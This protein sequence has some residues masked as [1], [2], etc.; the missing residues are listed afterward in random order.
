MFLNDGRVVIS[1]FII[2]FRFLSVVLVIVFLYG[3]FIF[4]SWQFISDMLFLVSA[5]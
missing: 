4:K 1:L 2:L 5:T 3:Y